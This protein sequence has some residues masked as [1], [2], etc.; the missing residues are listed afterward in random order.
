MP[1][2][3]LITT[4]A[5]VIC[6]AA[7]L[8]LAVAA[9]LRRA[10]RVLPQ[11]GLILAGSLLIALALVV[12]AVRSGHFSLADRHQALLFYVVAVTVVF[13]FTARR[14]DLRGLWLIVLPYVTVLAAF[15]AWGAFAHRPVQ[16][17]IESPWLILHVLTALLGYALFTLASVYAAAF[18][19]QDRSLRRKQFGQTF[20][21]LPP[22][23]TLEAL[24][25][26]QVGLAFVVFTAAIALGVVLAHIN[27]W[28]RAWLTDP[29]ILATALTWAVYAVLLYLR[30]GRLYCGRRAAVVTLAGLACLLFTFVGVPLLTD[31][32]H[33]FAA[34]GQG[35]NT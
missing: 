31:S 16:P 23:E 8:A 15:G 19:V 11:A 20:E 17:G 30:L 13:F 12:D 21:A 32:M 18:L 10:N 3:E 1:T 29:K 24:M 7:A 9:P 35:G 5:G 28:G 25:R 22:L 27:G 2:F 26:R 4:M 6:Y 33:D 14:H 34:S